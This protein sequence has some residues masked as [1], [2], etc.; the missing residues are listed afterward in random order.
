MP[1]QSM[2]ARAKHVAGQMWTVLHAQ[3]CSK[4]GC[5]VQGCMQTRALMRLELQC[6]RTGRELTP[7]QQA[8]CAKARKLIAHYHDCRVAR[9]NSTP[10]QPHYCLVCSLVARARMAPDETLRRFRL[11]YSVSPYSPEIPAS[12]ARRLNTV[13]E[14]ALP[15][16]SGLQRRRS[17]SWDGTN[18]QPTTSRRRKR[19]APVQEPVEDP[20]QA[21][22]SLHFGASVLSSLCAR[23]VPSAAAA[24]DAAGLGPGAETANLNEF[25]V[26]EKRHRSASWGG[27][28]CAE[29]NTA[30]D[31]LAGADSP[32]PPILGRPREGS[33]DWAPALPALSD[34][35]PAPLEAS[36]EALSASLDPT[37]AVPNPLEAAATNMLRHHEATTNKPVGANDAQVSLMQLADAVYNV[38]A[39]PPSSP[40]V[41]AC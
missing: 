8:A 29:R 33:M 5:T 4:P 34:A 35:N 22:A 7:N 26:V 13:P 38:E 21:A 40:V 17:A 24:S 19:S 27:E 25:P 1:V 36:S 9:H 39:P 41:R 15:S 28:W 37:A 12:V 31:L 32:P 2:V 3:N 18:A 20:V 10:K 14:E 16:P 23:P 30:T 6:Q 11:D